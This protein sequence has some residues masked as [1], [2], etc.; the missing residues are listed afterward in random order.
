MGYPAFMRKLAMGAHA[1]TAGSITRPGTADPRF[2]EERAMIRIENGR[3]PVIAPTP[4]KY[5]HISPPFTLPDGSFESDSL[6]ISRD[7][8]SSKSPDN[9]IEGSAHIFPYSM[10]SWF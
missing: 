4:K 8:Q 2:S 1:L 10:C 3:I 7:N 6:D 5:H 9:L